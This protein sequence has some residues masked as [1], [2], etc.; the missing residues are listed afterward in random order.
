MSPIAEFGLELLYFMDQQNENRNVVEAVRVAM[1]ANNPE[2]LADLYPQWFLT[3]PDDENVVMDGTPEADRIRAEGSYEED[4]SDVVWVSP[5]QEE[6]E[7]LMR[8]AEAVADSKHVIMSQEEQ[9]GEW[10]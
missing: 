5:G 7:E 4:Y 9:G 8:L 2:R 6:F 3:V 10:Y 1:I